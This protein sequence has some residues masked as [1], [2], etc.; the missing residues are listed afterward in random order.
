[1]MSSLVLSDGL[2]EAAKEGRSAACEVLSPALPTTQCPKWLPESNKRQPVGPRIPAGQREDQAGPGQGTGP[3]VEV[4]SG[5]RCNQ[6]VI[7]D[8]NHCGVET[9][10]LSCH[11]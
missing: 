3:G 10:V 7:V 1:M 2:P 8:R 9:P 11:K 5:S 6:S 4:H